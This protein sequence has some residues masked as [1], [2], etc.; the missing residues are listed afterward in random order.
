M[1]PVARLARSGALRRSAA[2]LAVLLAC[3]EGSDRADTLQGPDLDEVLTRA[4]AYVTAFYATLGSIVLEED[5]V[6]EVLQGPT[7]GGR[8]GRTR[9]RQLRADLLMVRLAAE[10]RWVQ[11]RDVFEVDGRVVRDR[12]ERLARL[13]LQPLSASSLDQAEAITRESARYNLGGIER[14]INLPVMAL[15]Y[16]QPAHRR[17]STFARVDAGDVKAWAGIA[18]APA[19]WAVSYQETG[20]DTLI[21]TS[22]ERDLPAS[23]RAWIDTATGRILRTELV[24]KSPEV[25]GRIDVRYRFDEALEGLVPDEM[26]EEYSDRQMSRIIG[27]AR[28][29]HIRRFKVTTDETLKKPP[30]YRPSRFEGG[31]HR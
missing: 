21:R 16:F 19:I 25:R 2:V 31:R 26:R 12:D 5:Y 4:G 17:R 9:R 15:T 27:R 3:V 7:R 30:G 18:S 13:F 28:Y 20:P 1:K 8:S 24:A 14:T 23:G 10:E 6:Q 29:G 22:G 11:F